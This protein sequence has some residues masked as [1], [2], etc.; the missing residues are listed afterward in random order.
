MDAIVG[1]ISELTEDIPS[2]LP[3]V[4]R[5]SFTAIFGPGTSSAI[6]EAN[7]YDLFDF[8]VTE[9]PDFKLPSSFGGTS[10]GAVWRFYIGEKDGT[11]SVVDSRLIGVPFFETPRDGKMIIS[12]HGPKSIYGVLAD[13]IAKRWP[14][15]STL[16][17]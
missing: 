2:G 17:G 16:A 5:K 8:K 7:A 14:E 10:G 9:T 6:T 15:A 11:P 13:A 1:M 12:F 3:L 4:R